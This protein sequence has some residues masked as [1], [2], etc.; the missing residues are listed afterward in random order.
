LSQRTII[1]DQS[2][3]TARHSHLPHRVA[4]RR[5][6]FDP[7]EIHHDFPA[8]GLAG[9]GDQPAADTLFRKGVHPI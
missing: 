8:T 9:S 1:G 4:S 5:F 6:N 2:K 7:A 3:P